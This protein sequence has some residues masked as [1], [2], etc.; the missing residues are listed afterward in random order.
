[1]NVNKQK[2]INNVKLPNMQRKDLTGTLFLYEPRHEIFNNVVC[3]T[4]KGS[5]HSANMR[6]L[7]RASASHLDIL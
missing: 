2:T 5:D 1:M 7:I 3:A 4:G 6:S